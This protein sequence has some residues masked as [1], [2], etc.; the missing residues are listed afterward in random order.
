LRDG[1]T[2]RLHLYIRRVAVLL[3]AG[4]EGVKTA[5]RCDHRRLCSLTLLM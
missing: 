1:A 3:L 5:A 4:Y 2:R